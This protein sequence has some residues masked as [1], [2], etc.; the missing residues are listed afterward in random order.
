MSTLIIKNC[1]S[2]RFLL[3]SPGLFLSVAVPVEAETRKSDLASESMNPLSTLISLPFEN[4]TYLNVGPSRSTANIFNIKPIYPMNLGVVDDDLRE[5]NLIN[6]F[7][8]PV[9]WTEGQDQVVL[10][11]IN[12]GGSAPGSFGVGSAFGLGDITYQ[13][14]ITPRVSRRR[15]NWGIG[16]ALVIPTATEERFSSNK[17]SA[18]PAIVAVNITPKW[19]LGLITQNVWSFAGNSDAADVNSFSLQYTV[20]YKFGQ[21]Y[22]LTTAPVITANWEAKSG[23]RWAIPFGGGI[24][25]VFKINGQAVALDFGAYYYTERPQYHPDWYVQV[26]FNFLFPKN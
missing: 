8:I 26:L 3:L 10:D 6:R 12:L 14:F 2:I 24:G 22:Y 20:N 19:F 7:T 4:N 25:R 16:G 15:M 18:G 13:G 17:W 23:N 9:I 11:Q 1:T 5:W 21:G